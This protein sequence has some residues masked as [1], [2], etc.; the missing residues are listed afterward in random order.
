MSAPRNRVFEHLRAN[1]SS[2]IGSSALCIVAGGVLVAAGQWYGWAAVTY[3]AIMLVV[4]LVA[5]SHARQE[6]R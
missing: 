4:G 6:D 2:I 3:G 5:S 1:P